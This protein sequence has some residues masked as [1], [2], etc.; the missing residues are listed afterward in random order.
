MTDSEV[1]DLLII[2]GGINGIGIAADAAGRDLSVILCEQH[3]LASGTS[4]RSSKLIHGGLRYLEHYD[5]RLVREALRERE[6]LLQK[7][8][9]IIWPLSFIMPH[10]KMLR[11]AWLIRLGL[12]LYDHLYNRKKLKKSVGI[13]L[14]QNEAGQVL[15]PN[16][17]NGFMYTDCW[18]DDARLVILNA[19]AAREKGAQIFTRTTFIGAERKHDYWQVI[20]EDKATGKTQLIKTKVLINAAGP[21]VEKILHINLRLAEGQHGTLVKGSHIVVPKIHADQYAYLLQNKDKRIVFVL[22]FLNKY[23]LVGTTD[24]FYNQDL[25]NVNITSE[26]VNY[27][28]DSVNEYFKQKV[29]P[30]QVIWNYSGVRS[31]VNN[32]GKKA[33]EISRDYFVELNTESDQAP[34]LTIFGGKLTTYRKLAEHVLEKLKYLFPNLPP[35]WTADEPLPG[36]NIP[37]ADFEKFYSAFSKKFPW[38]P[39]QLS[40]RYARSY[41]TLVEKIISGAKS[42]DD[43]GKHLGAGLYEAELNYLIQHE[44]AKSAEDILW[45]RTK[46]GVGLS[47]IEISELS[48]NI[49]QYF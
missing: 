8:P 40:Y 5:F 33:S 14:A 12:F 35:A 24:I 32:A 16:F 13:K 41:G 10:N 1:V 3:D 34:L 37:G 6:V 2:G 22:P 48:A 47:Q 20:L 19:I 44:W 15:K 38:L 39:E 42:L 25:T 21:W 9:H 23:S 26:E 46:L 18:V 17:K 11:P 30:E 49:E 28:C 43:L 45:R 7:A 29:S 4:S 27:L 31:L 36:G